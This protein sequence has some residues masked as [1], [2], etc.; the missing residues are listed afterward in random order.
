MICCIAEKN[1]WS[2]LFLIK[3]S[4][5]ILIFYGITK[6]LLLTKRSDF[7]V[8]STSLTYYYKSSLLKNS[9]SLPS[10]IWTIM[11][12][13]PTT[14][15]SCFHTSMFFS[16][17]VI[18]ISV[19]FYSIRAKVLLQFRYASAY[20]FSSCYF[21]RFFQFGLLGTWSWCRSFWSTSYST[22]KCFFFWVMII[23]LFRIYY[24]TSLNFMSLLAWKSCSLIY[25]ICRKPSREFWVITDFSFAFFISASFCYVYW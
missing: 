15:Q 22:R 18:W 12:A 1:M 16:Y 5:H 9:G 24:L 11:S 4:F 23:F 6:S 21:V 2:I 8:G 3:Y 7:F 14:L 17:G 20:F 19:F 25:A 10:T 13:R